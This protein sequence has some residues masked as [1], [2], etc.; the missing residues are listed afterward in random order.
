MEKRAEMGYIGDLIRI[1][2]K[3][4]GLSQMGL[5]E[6]IG[7]SYQQVQKYEKGA[8]EITI[9]RLA[10]IAHALNMPLSSFIPEDEKMM[11]SEAVSS[12]GALSNNEIEL[13]GLF[14]KIKNKK[15]RDGLVMAIKGMA[16]LSEK[17]H[18]KKNS[19]A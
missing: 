14:R 15:L 2:R 4:A 16:E 19:K 1:A 13:L 18:T 10:Q 7:V 9:P 12:Y 6:K 3:T 17:K 5:A 11:V 8:S